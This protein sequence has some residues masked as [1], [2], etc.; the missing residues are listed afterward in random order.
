MFSSNL[1]PRGQCRALLHAC[2]HA[3]HL[4]FVQEKQRKT[5]L[6]ATPEMR[7]RA[8][9]HA[10]NVAQKSRKNA[11]FLGI[12]NPKNRFRPL[13]RPT[14]AD[15]H[16]GPSETV[17]TKPSDSMWC[18]CYINESLTQELWQRMKQASHVWCLR[19]TPYVWAH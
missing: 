2:S 8:R 13:R 11:G 18:L 5:W 9:E 10:H 14:S 15:T 12:L 7:D 4:A 17:P 3:A 16:E 1:L 6:F 19:A